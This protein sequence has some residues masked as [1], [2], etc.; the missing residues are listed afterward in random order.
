MTL[1]LNEEQQ[2]LKDSAKSFVDDQW[3]LNQ[4]RLNRA[5]P[6][7]GSIDTELWQ[8]MVELGWAAIP[9]PEE[10]GGLG[11]GYAELGIVMEEAGRK[12][13]ISPLL[14][15]VVLSGSAIELAGNDHVRLFKL[16]RMLRSTTDN[17]SLAAKV[18]RQAIELLKALAEAPDAKAGHLAA[19]AGIYEYEKDIG[20]AIECYRHA[21][22]LDYGQVDWRMKCAKLLARAD[23]IPEA[24]HEARICL[25]LRP[26]MAAAQ[27]LI[28]ELSVQGRGMRPS[29]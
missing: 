4:L 8:K 12:L 10:F 7:T 17:K 25:R 9:F 19:V 23:K 3:Q 16:E 11:L 14:S 15:S 28:E 6:K 27:K 18:R 2:L 1:I 5:A 26:Q 29:P 22:N 24:I 13:L 21:L 20:A